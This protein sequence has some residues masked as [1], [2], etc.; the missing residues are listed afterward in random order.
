MG[1]VASEVLGLICGA[2]QLHRPQGTLTRCCLNGDAAVHIWLCG[3]K[4]EFKAPPSACVLLY[5]HPNLGR[6]CLLRLKD[7]LVPALQLG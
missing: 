6:Y 1:E 4:P 7:D 5:Y 3:F 2:I